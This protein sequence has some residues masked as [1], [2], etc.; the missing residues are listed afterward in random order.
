MSVLIPTPGRD[1]VLFKVAAFG[2]NQADLLLTRGEHYMRAELPVR[3]GYEGSGTVEAIGEDVTRF[4]VG[5]RVTCIPNVDGPYSTAGKYALAKE[6]HLTPWPDGWSAVEATSLWMQ[7]LTPYFPFVEVFPF[8]SGDW[9]M[10]T[11]ATG[12]TGLG[13]V[14]LAKLL[15]ARVIAT[16]RSQSKVDVL[17]QH[18]AD[19]VCS[20]D[21]EDFVAK[22]MSATENRGVRLICDTLAGHY[23]PLLSQTLSDEGIM[24][25]HGTLAG[26]EGT[27]LPLRN[28]IYRRGGIFG[29]SLINEL[30][31]PGALER[32]RDFILEAV[33]SGALP[34]PLID[35]TFPFADVRNAYER[36]RGGQ[37]TGKI[38]A[39]MDH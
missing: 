38:V 1:E 3:I 35:R 16:T 21:D 7:F 34:S 30:R 32:G 36:M 19:V 12:G 10:I 27:S 8:Q 4:A 33:Q 6:T 17:K 37:Q 9:V 23:V 20:T 26:E 39:V 15:G 14:R 28:L 18:G 2:L 25:V 22:V 31:R 5:D 24:F 13:S 29:Y 11:A